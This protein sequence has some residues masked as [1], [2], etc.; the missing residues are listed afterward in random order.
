MPHDLQG[1]RF[2]EL[3]EEHPLEVYV[4]NTGSVGGK[5]G[6]EGAAKVRIPHSSA[7]V[8]GIAEGTIEWER[9][10]DFGYL[11]ASSVPGI[12]P[13]DSD[14]LHPKRLYEAQG[15]LEE[16]ERLVERFKAERTAFLGDF[17]SLS[18]E[19]VSAVG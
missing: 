4:M 2:L 7:I 16:Y 1:N 5:A 9:D 14:V 17:P 11:I 18:D 8:K 10:P 15:R 13:D 12:D 6:A 3:L 19:I